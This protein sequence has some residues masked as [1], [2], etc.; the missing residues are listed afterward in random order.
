M[1]TRRIPLAR[2]PFGP[3]PGTR[4]GRQRHPPPTRRGTKTLRPRDAVPRTIDWRRIVGSRHG[5]ASAPCSVRGSRRPASCPDGP[6]AGRQPPEPRARHAAWGPPHAAACSL[7]PGLSSR[8]VGGGSPPRSGPAVPASRL[9][10]RRGLPPRPASA[11][12][13][14]V[15]PSNWSPVRRRSHAGPTPAHPE[16]A[17]PAPAG[18]R[19][20]RLPAGSCRPLRGRA[21]LRAASPVHRRIQHRRSR[22]N[23]PR[24]RVP[25]PRAAGKPTNAADRSAALHDRRSRIVSH[26]IYAGFSGNDPSRFRPSRLHHSTHRR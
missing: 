22:R 2:R 1:S 12:G 4:S 6:T 25:P 26:T 3:V 9:S 15:I 19:G 24:R 16:P 17:G 5:W 23:R 14:A 21:G 10:A 20:L 18:P 8:P 11:P 7:A 13:A